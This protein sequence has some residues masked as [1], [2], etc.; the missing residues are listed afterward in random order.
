M[1]PDERM[2]GV[3]LVLPDLS[4]L[5]PPAPPPLGYLLTHGH[6]DHIGALGHALR[7][8]PAPIYGTAL[9]LELAER[10]LAEA[11]G[12]PKVELR[13]ILPG[14]EISFG[15]SFR[16][17][18][19]RVTHSIPEAVSFAIRTPHGLVLHTGDYKL[20]GRGLPALGTDVERFTALGEEGV[21]LVVGDSTG[22]LDP[23]CS[24][25]ESSVASALEE[26]FAKARG[27]IVVA[28]FSSHVER[29]SNLASL[30][31]SH[32]RRLGWEGRRL[33]ETAEAAA[34][35][36]LLR[37]PPGLALSTRG[38]MD[39]PPERAALAITGTQG[40]PGSV[41]SLLALGEHPLLR[42]EPGDTVVVS[43]RILPGSAGRMAFLMDRLVATGVTVVDPQDHPGVHA[44]GHARRD[45][46]E[47]LLRL[48][49][50]RALL[51]VHGRR[52][53]LTAHAELGRA[54]GLQEVLVPENGDVLQIDAQGLRPQGRLRAGR[55]LVDGKGVGDVAEQVLGD[56]RALGET[57]VVIALLS[58]CPN[59]GKLLIPPALSAVGVAIPETQAALLERASAALGAALE[60]LPPT[61]R[62]DRD[63]ISHRV[64]GELRRF[65]RRELG[66]RPMVIPVV[67]G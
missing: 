53:M 8:A 65:F 11:P 31:L 17:E 40:E 39:L 62:Q 41:L 29:L 25:P 63:E 37:L 55:I 3:D 19:I 64:Q 12:A 26:V 30:A 59:T 35:L 56:R 10:R 60:A 54:M 21:R 6:E 67:L 44:S 38:L 66:R 58:L 22:A 14:R 61:I 15:S 42:L 57:G 51:P 47:R 32:G 33:R 34:R 1:F 16:V 46:I 20:E 9:T 52:R 45:D 28:I 5:G 7:L 43:A 4:A 24:P 27:R 36:G 13:P 50:P 2:P 48:L 23:G 18:P 49:R